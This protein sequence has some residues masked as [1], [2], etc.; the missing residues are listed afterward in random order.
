MGIWSVFRKPI[1]RTHCKALKVIAPNEDYET[2]IGR[3][4]NKCNLLLTEVY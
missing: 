4:D 2:Y 3:H 1:E